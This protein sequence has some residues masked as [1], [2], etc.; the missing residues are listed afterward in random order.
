MSCHEIALILLESRGC[1]PLIFHEITS[2]VEPDGLFEALSPTAAFGGFGFGFN[3][4]NA[5]PRT[6]SW[7]WQGEWLDAGNSEAYQF[8]Y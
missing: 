1:S 6:G 4:T 8:Q 2:Q 3:M 7:E 5:V